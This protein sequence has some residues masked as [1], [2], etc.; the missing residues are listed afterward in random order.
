MIYE[1]GQVHYS[2][3]LI[4][5]NISITS[6]GV[7]EL[8]LMFTPVMESLTVFTNKLFDDYQYAQADSIF[9]TASTTEKI[10]RSRRPYKL[11]T[12]QQANQS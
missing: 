10:I 9:D 1:N 5:A 3:D 12:N 11:R 6:D 7:R 4:D 8:E 2:L